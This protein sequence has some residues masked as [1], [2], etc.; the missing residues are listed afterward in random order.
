[1]KTLTVT[2]GERVNGILP[3]LD[4]C[5]SGWSLISKILKDV[6][7][8]VVSE[9]EWV[10]ANRQV[11]GPDAEGRVSWKWDE[12]EETK[13]DIQLTDEVAEYILKKIE[14][15]GSNNELTIKDRSL[16]SLREKLS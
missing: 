2:I 5:K 11:I 7:N 13:K 8:I 9:D 12:G 1:M 3:I 16:I 10:K 14:E 15:K 6:D 4:E